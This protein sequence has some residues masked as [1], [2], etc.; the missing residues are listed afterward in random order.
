MPAEPSSV[1]D[2]TNRGNA[3]PSGRLVARR[4]AKIANSGTSCGRAV[5]EEI[6]STSVNHRQRFERTISALNTE[7][8]EE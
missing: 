1:S 7:I 4:L 6:V 5:Y 2:L 3:R 8:I